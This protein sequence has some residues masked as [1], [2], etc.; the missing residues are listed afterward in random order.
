MSRPRS[1]LSVESGEKRRISPTLRDAEDGRRERRVRNR[2]AVVDAMLQLLREG[3]LRPGGQQIADRAGVSLRTVF[4][5]FDDLDSLM[6]AAVRQQLDHV[7]RLFDL[8][9]INDRASLADRVDVLARHRERLFEEIAPVR[10]AGTRLAPFHAP[11]REALSSSHRTLRRQLE[12]VFQRELAA[13]PAD[14]RRVAIEAADAASSFAT[15]D[16]MRTDQRLSALRA[17]AAMAAA[18]T[19]LLA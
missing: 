14:V 9:A 7:G 19:S 12:Q 2:D 17:R 8:A 16:A 11:V 1:E 4:R 13:M 6:E 15:W 18:L 3:E 5:H 10:R